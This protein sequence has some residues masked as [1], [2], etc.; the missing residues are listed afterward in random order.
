L[1]RHVPPRNVLGHDL[2]ERTACEIRLGHMQGQ[3][4]KREPCA[5]EGMLGAEIGKQPRL[6]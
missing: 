2:N 1:L 5:D 4:A 6:R 3:G